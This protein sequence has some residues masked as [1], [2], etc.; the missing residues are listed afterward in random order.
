MT[1]GSHKKIRIEET[2]LSNTCKINCRK[3][4]VEEGKEEQINEKT[5]DGASSTGAGNK[6]G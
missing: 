4:K 3:W 6:Q 2:N 1:K 5:V